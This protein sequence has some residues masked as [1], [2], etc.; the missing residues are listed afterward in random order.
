MATNPIVINTTVNTSGLQ[1]GM[2]SSVQ[3]SKSALD[4]MRADYQSAVQAQISIGNTFAQAQQAA[5]QATAANA[6]ATQQAAT[7]YGIAFTGAVQA[8]TAAQ[9]TWIAAQQQAAQVVQIEALQFQQLI[10]SI[11]SLNSALGTSAIAQGRVN[12]SA[13]LAGAGIF[14]LYTAFVLL[15]R[16]IDEIDKVRQSEENLKH[17]SEATGI[18]AV[19]IAQLQGAINLSGGDSD[20]FDSAIVRLTRS[21]ERAQRNSATYVDELRRLGVTTRDPIEAFF[22][23]ADKIHNTSDRTSAL[24]AATRVLG[25]SEVD[26]IG[27]MSGGSAALR[28]NYEASRGLAEARANATESAHQLTVAERSLGAEF[29]QI[30]I[31]V[32]PPFTV[33]VRLIAETLALAGLGLKVILNEIS[34][35]GQGIALYTRS[36]FDAL[37]GS[38]TKAAIEAQLA[39]RS[40]SDSSQSVREKISADASETEAFI[41]RLS[42]T[43]AA[44]AG[45]GKDPFAEVGDP[46]AFKKKEDELRKAD[47]EALADTQ[48]D[49]E[50]FLAELRTFWESRLATE[51]QYGDRVREIKRTLGHLNQDID[52]ELDR[53]EKE[54]RRTAQEEAKKDLA[55]AYKSQKEQADQ[56]FLELTA[57]HRLSQQQIVDYWTEVKKQSQEGS[58]LYVEAEKKIEEA[59]KKEREETEKLA[60]AK[61]K[62]AEKTLDLAHALA[63]EKIKA[64]YEIQ[65]AGGGGT[66][67]SKVKEDAALLAED[68]RYYA[69]KVALA[70]QDADRIKAVE[71]TNTANYIKAQ[72][73]VVN[74]QAVADTK[75]LKD[76][77]KLTIDLKALWAPY[78]N[79][80]NSGFTKALGDVLTGSK[81]FAA[82]M[83][84]IWTSIALSVIETWALIPIKWAEDQIRMTVATQA[85]NTARTASNVTAA[86]AGNSIGLIA[87]IQQG[88]RAASVAAQN[89]YAAV[90][91]VPIVG[92]ILAPEAAAAAYV[93]VLGLAAF[94]QG[95]YVPRTGVALLHAGEQVVN[96]PLTS[97]LNNIANGGNSQSQ[98]FG[99]FHYHEASGNGP[100]RTPTDA[101][102]MFDAFQKELRRRNKSYSSR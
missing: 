19:R 98:S 9:Q 37:T 40:I 93:A 86:A 83:H 73:E 95:G 50:V 28:E 82:S 34:G 52:K 77:T 8:A 96:A 54:D 23:I 46:K 75:I 6:K 12:S 90:S 44:P 10:I 35:F 101:K 60:E 39:A 24:S 1:S 87:A 29:T 91:A 20:K 79:T 64:P 16:G 15:R 2:A 99:A 58:T 76:Q 61:A 55:A 69:Q 94:E 59:L 4:Q 89:T 7:T 67:N 41:K 45:P 51:S 13:G 65:S 3:I 21:M 32:I 56:A 27:I 78:F 33:A 80:F 42:A 66:N 92:P 62:A 72:Q 48:A 53:I 36:V 81:S 47:E 14:R 63:E 100:S 102:S 49:H 97:M 26:L 25:A 85:G 88:A 17:F 57:V 71:G 5:A 38:Y 74:A 22:Q 11:N 70:Q 68:Q 30:G 18:S 84:Q 43:S 31:A